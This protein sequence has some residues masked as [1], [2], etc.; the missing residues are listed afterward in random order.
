MPKRPVKVFESLLASSMGLI[1]V[2]TLNLAQA[3]TFAIEDLARA[4]RL[5][6]RSELGVT[7][8]IEYAEALTSNQWHLLT[9]VVVTHI[10]Y[11]VV[12]LAAPGVQRFYRVRIS[13]PSM[14]APDGM[15]LIP[16]GSFQMG[17]TFGEG[18]ANERPVHSV[19]VSAYYMDKCEVTK[20]LWDEVKGWT[21]GNGYAFANPGDGKAANHPVQSV[22]W[23]DVVKWCNAR[24]QKE[25]RVPAYYSDPARTQVYKTGQMAPYVKWDAGFRLPTEAEWEKAARGG[26]GGHRY[27]WWDANTITHSRANY[28]SRP[29][30]PYDVSVTRGYHPRYWVGDWP[31]SSPVGS[32][33][34]N[35]YGLHDMAGNVWEWCWD[36]TGSYSSESQTDP[37]G[38]QSGSYRVV[39]GGSWCDSA[40]DCRPSFCKNFITPV[41]TGSNYG[42]RSVL[43]PGQP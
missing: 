26:E 4:P 29:D 12:D 11:G 25:G 1:V 35:G 5:T 27:P 7:H 31:F 43:P 14:N 40:F 2:G 22:N 23:Y 16:A 24:S 8:V 42:F 20:A 28:H 33:A 34:A 17:D 18:R 38:S 13:Q 30:E 3:A 36:W 10:P 39:R 21:R 32:F 9:N 19:F 6:I 15:A 41:N 37:R